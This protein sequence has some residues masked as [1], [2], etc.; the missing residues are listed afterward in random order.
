MLYLFRYLIW[1]LILIELVSEI[2]NNLGQ[3]NV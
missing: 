3:E 2:L 1:R